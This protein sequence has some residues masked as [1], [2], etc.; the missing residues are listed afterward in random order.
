MLL[1]NK[2]RV[3]RHSG[4][5]GVIPTGLH[6]DPQRS[7][8]TVSWLLRQQLQTPQNKKPEARLICLSKHTKI[9]EHEGKLL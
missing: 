8:L 4:Q 5:F 2:T 1:L 7:D 9:W 3:C 6:I